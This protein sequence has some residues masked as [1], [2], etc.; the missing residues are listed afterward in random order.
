[1]ID[2]NPNESKKMN[3]IELEEIYI[4]DELP[5]NPCIHKI[6]MNSIS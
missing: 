6:F 1:V 2:D 3:S 4:C 5:L